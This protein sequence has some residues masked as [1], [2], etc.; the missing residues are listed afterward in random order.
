MDLCSCSQFTERH[1]TAEILRFAQDDRQR[2]RHTS[3]DQGPRA[4]AKWIPAFAGMTNWFCG[5]RMTS[6][7]RQEF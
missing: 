5:N 6:D 7:E 4:E 3:S 1:E 2:V